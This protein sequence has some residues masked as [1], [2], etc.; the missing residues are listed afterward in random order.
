VSARCQVPLAFANFHALCTHS[1][2]GVGEGGKPLTFRRS[3]I[4]RVSKGRFF[5]GGDITLG[6]GSGGDSIYG[7]RGFEDEPF[8]LKLCHDAPGLLTM[9]G[10]INQ[11][12]FRVTLGPMPE[13]NGRAVI[14]GRLVS[15]AMHLASLESQPV[16]VE[17]RPVVPITVIECG[18]IP[19]WSSLPAP[20]PEVPKNLNVTVDSVSER[21]NELRTAVSDAVKEALKT[22][23]CVSSEREGV[24]AGS[25][26]STGISAS[27]LKRAAP[28][29]AST[30]VAK[31]GSMMALPFE[32]EM[33]ES[34]DEVQDECD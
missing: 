13:M 19:G 30:S 28:S 8:G 14:I 2:N 22:G 18:A 7:S 9:A 23:A 34:E 31:K 21:A 27:G 17:E 3:C 4:H 25:T 1:V 12:R 29:E 20:I 33:G 6:N 11:S 32:D 10:D 24:P 15:G 16:D 26:T 5:E